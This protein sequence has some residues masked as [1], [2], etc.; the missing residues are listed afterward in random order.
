MPF[1]DA[2][3]IDKIADTERVGGSPRPD[4]FAK[5]KE[6]SMWCQGPRAWW[7]CLFIATVTQRLA[8]TTTHERE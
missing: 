6:G 1:Q 2:R 3:G 4:I 5:S 8:I 7:M